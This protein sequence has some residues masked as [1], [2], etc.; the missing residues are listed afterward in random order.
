[1]KKKRNN[2]KKRRNLPEPSGAEGV[3][4]SSVEGER[5]SGAVAQYT[6]VAAPYPN[7]QQKKKKYQER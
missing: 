1:M 7:Y 5:T 2:K 6:D 4:G 3:R